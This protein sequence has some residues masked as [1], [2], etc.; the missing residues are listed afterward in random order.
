MLKS[1]TRSLPSML[2]WLCGSS[3]AIVKAEHQ[4]L[5]LANKTKMAKGLMTCRSQRSKDELEELK[6][7]Q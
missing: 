2:R 7:S 4:P 3:E 5:F 1:Q 6:D